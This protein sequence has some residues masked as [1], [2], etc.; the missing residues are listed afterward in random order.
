MQ[1]LFCW[2]KKIGEQIIKVLDGKYSGENKKIK[3]SE[4]R[5]VEQQRIN[6][7]TD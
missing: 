6:F 4:T 7:T 1:S 2:Q 5:Y 3:G